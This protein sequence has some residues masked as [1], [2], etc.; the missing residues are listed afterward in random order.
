[1]SAP[2]KGGRRRR[3]GGGEAHAD[4]RW[5][6]TYAD[7]ITLLMALFI[8]MWSISA[9]NQSKFDELKHSLK[10][11]FNGNMFEK[12]KA[13][14]SGEAQI[15]NPAG[16]QSKPIVQF[17]TVDIQKQLEQ[18]EQDNM[19]KVRQQIDGWAKQKGYQN[20]VKTKLDER[21]LVVR[22]VTDDVLFAPGQAVVQHDSVPLLR[23]LAGFLASGKIAN[24]I[25][26]EGH[27]D[28]TPIS[29][30]RFRSNWELST[31][32]ATAVLHELLGAGIRPTRLSV[33][34]YGAEQPLATNSTAYGRRTNR[35]VEIVVL[36]SFS[37][38]G[39]NK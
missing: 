16:A 31:G 32:R 27:T 8:V 3:G 14:L 4:E 17:P 22:L 18:R 20:K 5:L 13:L 6:L 38:G 15:L 39:N 10:S 35:R 24:A 23:H 37:L 2:A 36:R 1:V 21:G 34:G 9:V 28:S 25:R 12:D 11:A 7:M 30:S 19:E 26:V 33:V 29:T